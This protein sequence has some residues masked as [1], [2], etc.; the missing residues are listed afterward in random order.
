M[1]EELRDSG[2][3]VVAVAQEARGIAAAR[4]WIEQAKCTFWNLIDTNHKVSERF[5]MVNVP[6]AVWIDEQG[7][8]ARPAENAGSTNHFRRM[9]RETKAMAQSDIDQRAAARSLYLEAVRDWVRNGTHRLDARTIAN[10]AP[11][12]TPAAVSAQAHFKLGVWLREQGRTAES[13]RQ[14]TEASRLH[15][16][17]WCIWRQAADLEQV[18]KAVGP[19]FWARVDALGERPYYPAPDIPGFPRP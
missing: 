6:E 8:I 9:N 12:L 2:F 18:G 1:F 5:G 11:R 17:S 19:E 16:D 4:P 3:M 13:D 7:R 10:R 15:P 14:F